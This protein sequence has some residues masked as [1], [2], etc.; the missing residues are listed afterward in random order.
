MHKTLAELE[1]DPQFNEFPEDAL[2]EVDG[3]AQPAMKKD[4][5]SAVSGSSGLSAKK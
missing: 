2:Y 5:K 4:V 3:F 1:D